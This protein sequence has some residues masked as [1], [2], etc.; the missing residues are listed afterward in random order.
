MF[1]PLPPVRAGRKA[2][3]G[4]ERRF[5]GRKGVRRNAD[6]SRVALHRAAR[7]ANVTALAQEDGG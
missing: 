7:S 3:S 2:D 1:Q 5:F 4:P 6:L